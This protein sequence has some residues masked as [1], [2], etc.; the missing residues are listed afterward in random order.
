MLKSIGDDGTKDDS[1]DTMLKIESWMQRTG[2]T[3]YDHRDTE[4]MKLKSVVEIY[5]F[6]SSLH[7]HICKLFKDTNK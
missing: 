4:K 3:E 2:A 5:F 6:G 7:V 1:L